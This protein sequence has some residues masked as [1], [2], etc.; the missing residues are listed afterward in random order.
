MRE[1]I[2]L[3]FLCAVLAG[4]EGVAQWQPVRSL[5]I[6]NPFQDHPAA[7]GSAECLDLHI[8]HRAQW[9][10]IEGAPTTSY[11]NLHGQRTN[12]GAH[13]HGYGVRIESDQAGAWSE[14]FVRFGWAYN[15]RLAQGGRF[16]AGLSAGLGQVRLDL[17]NLRLPEVGA[18]QDPA[19]LAASQGVGPE[20]DLGVWYYDREKYAGLTLSQL[21][22]PTL[23]RISTGTRISRQALAV[24]GMEFDLEG[25]WKLEPVLQV[26]LGKG[27]PPVVDA[28]AWM[29]FDDRF[30]LAAGYRNQSAMLFGFRTRI[31]N[32]LTV[33]YAYDAGVGPLATTSGGSHEVV[34]GINA[35]SGGGPGRYVKCPAYD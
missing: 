32:Y 28:W 21:T 6:L 22:Q 30:A 14:T 23:S 29:H 2:Y 17:G 19:V 15:M 10:G 18:A 13:F 3:V 34:L 35:C 25:R 7:A 1:R 4:T 5:G 12:G 20:I 11:A 24:A 31:A 27:I 16:A 8:G 9:T 33:A 26:R